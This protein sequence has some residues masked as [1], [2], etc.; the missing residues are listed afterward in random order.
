MSNTRKQLATGLKAIL[1]G[2]GAGMSDEPV[3]PAPPVAAVEAPAA[4]QQAP[5]LSAVEPL[6]ELSA[7]E[8]EP[9]AEMPAAPVVST[10]AVTAAPLPQ[11]V[12][13][14]APKASKARRKAEPELPAAS[15]STRVGTLERPYMR[16]RD[17]QETRKV[18]VVLPVDLAERMQI[19]CVK[20]RIRPNAFMEQAILEALERA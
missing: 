7:P 15:G 19:H 2:A 14:P 4:E 11:V 10:P 18:G 1:G 13:Q 20:M 16:Q 5:V 3:V 8:Q 9:E 17:Q 12:A 6:A